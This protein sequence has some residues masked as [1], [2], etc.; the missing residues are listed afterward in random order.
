MTLYFR[1]SGILVLG[2]GVDRGAAWSWRMGVGAELALLALS[3][4]RRSPSLLP[5]SWPLWDQVSNSRGNR[6][7]RRLW[8]AA[9]G[10]PGTFLHPKRV[11]RVPGARGTSQPRPGPW[12]RPPG[13]LPQDAAKLL[14]KRRYSC[15]GRETALKRERKLRGA[16]AAPLPEV[17]LFL[18]LFCKIDC[19]FRTYSLFF[20][21]IPF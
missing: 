1:D 21:F 19:K 12:P 16:A 10:A 17:L 5:V 14:A 11:P 15:G 3:F 7:P 4:K 8:R 6:S 2:I 20:F 18:L 9:R 13:R